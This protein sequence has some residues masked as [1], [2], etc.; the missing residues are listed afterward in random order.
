MTSLRA[1]LSSRKD[2]TSLL[3]EELKKAGLEKEYNEAFFQRI[4]SMPPEDVLL[5]ENIPDDVAAKAYAAYKG[6]PYASLKGVEPEPEALKA[7]PE[8]VITTYGI[9]PFKRE[10][11]TVIVA[12]S[13]VDPSIRD[14]LGR[15][16][17]DY[18]IVIAPKGAIQTLI[19]NHVTRKQWEKLIKAQ[20]AAETPKREAE[21]EDEETPVKRLFTDIV[22][23]AYRERASDIHIEPTKEGSLRIRFRVDG[24]L[25]ER[26]PVDASVAPSLIVAIKLEAHLRIEERRLPQDGRIVLS[27][28][29]VSLRVST[30]PTVHGE[31]VVLRILPRETD[32][33]DLDRIGFLPDVLAMYHKAITHP[34][35]IVLVTG[36]T[37]SGKST[38]LAATIKEIAK[39]DIKVLSVEDPVEYPIPGVIQHQVNE[40]AGYTFA[41]ALRAFLRQDPDVI[42]VGEIRDA[43]TAHIAVQAAL[44]GHLV[45]GTLHTNDAPSTV[46]RL[47]QMGVE[48]YNL[49]PTLRGVLAQRLVRRVCLSCAAPL[50]E[51]EARRILEE[52]ASLRLDTSKANLLKG[53][54]CERCGGTGY[55]G[56][57]TI[58]EFM[59][60][61]PEI[62]EAIAKGEPS[63]VIRKLAVNAGMKS[64]YQDGLEKVLMGLT[65]MEEVLKQAFDETEE[66]ALRPDEERE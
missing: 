47:L 65:T 63:S 9:L 60:V 54:G 12:T 2:F 25:Q 6:L 56:R 66:E 18:K 50:E 8:A 22:Q 3:R 43:E 31:M 55:K 21:A 44:T 41:R 24:H 23:Q 15:E 52:A 17:N 53:R 58:H 27:D 37:G 32:I 46:T 64:L 7:Y 28:P 39:P 48:P 59:W 34:N 20:R 26:P 45:F 19:E 38:T 16:A 13:R 62:E 33:P 51:K 14:A 36:P 1:F 5:R 61:T 40:E 57:T 4:A 11:N 35:G 49:A 30:G 42:Y 29:P 10:G